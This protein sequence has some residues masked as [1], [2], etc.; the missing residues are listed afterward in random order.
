MMRFIDA[1]ICVQARI[2]HHLVPAT[3]K[4]N[5]FQEMTMAFV[6]EDNLTDMGLERWKDIPDPRLRQI[7][8]R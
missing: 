5:S 7:C 1:G 2:N 8:S 3:S 4:N 6:T